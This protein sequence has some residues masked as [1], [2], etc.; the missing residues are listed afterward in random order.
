MK[1]KGV[2]QTWQD[3]FFLLRECPDDVT[4][5][6]YESGA[7]GDCRNSQ[8]K[9]PVMD[10]TLESCVDTA[11]K[12]QFLSRDEEYRGLFAWGESFRFLTEAYVPERRRTE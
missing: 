3:A 4:G 11:P 7:E 8:A 9:G 1:N 5:R 2:L 12:K 6:D 10:G